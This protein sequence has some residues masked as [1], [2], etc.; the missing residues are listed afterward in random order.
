MSQSATEASVAKPEN[1]V[2]PE[3]LSTT[4]HLPDLSRPLIESSN[5]DV[6]PATDLK[7]DQKNRHVHHGPGPQ[8]RASSY[9]VKDLV[10][11]LHKL[12]ILGG[13]Q[14]NCEQTRQAGENIYKFSFDKATD[15]SLFNELLIRVIYDV[16][17]HQRPSSCPL[18]ERI[19]PTGIFSFLSSPKWVVSITNQQKEDLCSLVA[20]HT[21][22]MEE[23]MRLLQENDTSRER[24]KT[25]S[26][27]GIVKP[28]EIFLKASEY[29]IY[30]DGSGMKRP[31]WYVLTYSNIE[32]ARAGL[33]ALKKIAEQNPKDFPDCDLF[34]R[35]AKVNIYN[36]KGPGFTLSEAQCLFLRKHLADTKKQRNNN[37]SFE[38]HSKFNPLMLA[39][40]LEQVV[41]LLNINTLNYFSELNPKTR[42]CSHKLI[43]QTEEQAQNAR[44]QL[45]QF[46]YDTRGLERESEPVISQL[47]GKSDN[48]YMWIF[49]I[50]PEQLT[51]L[52][53]LAV[54]NHTSNLRK[55]SDALEKH[56]G[57][58]ITNTY[59]KTADP[60]IESSLRLIRYAIV[61][62]EAQFG[63][64]ALKKLKK[65]A[66]S[67]FITDFPEHN[68]FKKENVVA[69]TTAKNHFEFLLYQA[70]GD[71]F[72]NGIE[73]FNSSSYAVREAYEAEPEDLPVE[74]ATLHSSD[75]VDT[76]TIEVLKSQY[77]L[78]EEALF[79]VD[80]SSA[81]GAAT[82]SCFEAVN[83]S[84]A[85]SSASARGTAS[86]S[87]SPSSASISSPTAFFHNSS[88]FTD[89][90]RNFESQPKPGDIPDRFF[91]QPAA[92]TNYS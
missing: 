92:S 54:V 26:D 10:A 82:I 79:S 28:N 49:S 40:P 87:S 67:R 41:T 20:Q 35:N 48:K 15:A 24:K 36:H 5:P 76:S 74:D 25:T 70:Q 13:S 11:A 46:I 91:A 80:S 73:S 6:I 72:M 86:L 60:E 83:L 57:L 42:R 39:T 30:V 9:S 61:Y 45:M 81:S 58:K 69:L 12:Y 52:F 56:T 53:Q 31:L 65:L 22:N 44:E 3:D 63:E 75:P 84:S 77:L 18:P 85:A 37:S 88:T 21:P 27:T 89:S 47:A 23:F 1:P 34:L 16:T 2:K 59:L 4:G 66:R 38:V 14:N 55:L 50:S 62:H 19:E 90:S 7:S 64:A 29:D 71:S 32:S 17:A 43:F 33:T 68:S 78:G 51:V 8:T